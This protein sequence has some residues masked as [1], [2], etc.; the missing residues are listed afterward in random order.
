MLVEMQILMK[1][2]VGIS[3]RGS[4]G[5][6]MVVVVPMAQDGGARAYGRCDFDGCELV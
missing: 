4:G 6:T 3:G 5:W 1:G 2:N